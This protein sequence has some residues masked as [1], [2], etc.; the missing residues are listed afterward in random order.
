M[1]FK[2]AYMSNAFCEFNLFEVPVQ[3]GS[4]YKNKIAPEYD[5]NSLTPSFPVPLPVIRAPSLVGK[6]NL[7]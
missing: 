3:C 5:C 1:L 6:E 7:K 4:M 2:A